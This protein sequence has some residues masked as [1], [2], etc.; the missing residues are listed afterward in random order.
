MS[1]INSAHS[2][3]CC[4]MSAIS[5]SGL[6]GAGAGEAGAAGAAGAGEDSD[7]SATGTSAGLEGAASVGCF[8]SEL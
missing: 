7:G 5:Y 4:V 3:F 1:A 6:G 2:V 8:A